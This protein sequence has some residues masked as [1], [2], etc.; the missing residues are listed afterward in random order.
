MVSD[1]DD[2]PVDGRVDVG[3]GNRAD[4]ERAE[5]SAL[6]LI[7]GQPTT[8]RSGDAMPQPREQPFVRLWANGL[9]NERAVGGAVKSDC[10]HPTLSDR[11]LHAQVPDGR[12]HLRLGWSRGSATAGR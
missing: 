10:R 12:E 9:E 8:R 1:G 11:R 2:R 7:P 4:I 3:T 6:E 5:R